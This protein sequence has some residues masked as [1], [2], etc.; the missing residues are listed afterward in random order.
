MTG[1]AKRAAFVAGGDE[2]KQQLGGG[3]AR[4]LTRETIATAA[5][6]GAG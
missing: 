5:R 6:L 2:P 3:I 1:D 4:L